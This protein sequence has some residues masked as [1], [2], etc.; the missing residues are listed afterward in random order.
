MLPGPVQ[1]AKAGAVG[2]TL[3]G[4]AKLVFHGIRVNAVS[5]SL[6][7]TVRCCAGSNYRMVCDFD[8]GT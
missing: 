2:L 1:A 8:S 6:T 4:A 7:V 5:P 3:S